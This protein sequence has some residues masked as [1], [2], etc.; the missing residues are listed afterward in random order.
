MFNKNALIALS[1][2]FLLAGCAG[3]TLDEDAARDAQLAECQ[4][5]Q[6]DQ[7]RLDC[8]ERITLGDTATEPAPQSDPTQQY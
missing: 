7:E 2:I 8:I 5:I 6:D 3:H 1:G 4:L